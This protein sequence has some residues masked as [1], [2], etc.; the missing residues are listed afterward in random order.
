MP[1]SFEVEHVIG[2]CYFLSLL[3][4]SLVI[5]QLMASLALSMFLAGSVGGGRLMSLGKTKRVG[6]RPGRLLPKS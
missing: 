5:W 1:L 3:H 2:L 4:P 6:M